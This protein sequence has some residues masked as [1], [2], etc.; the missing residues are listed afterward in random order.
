MEDLYW[1][2]YFIV[3]I[4][5]ALIVAY[6]MYLRDE[7]FGNYQLHKNNIQMVYATIILWPILMIFFIHEGLFNNE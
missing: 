1:A 2:S 5:C 3:G 4:F 7:I 6:R